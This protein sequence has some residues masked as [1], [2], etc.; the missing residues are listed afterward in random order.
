MAINQ[1]I[2][3]TLCLIAFII[4]CVVVYLKVY[5]VKWYLYIIHYWTDYHDWPDWDTVTTIWLCFKIEDEFSI[6]KTRNAIKMQTGEAPSIKDYKLIRTKRC[7]RG[8]KP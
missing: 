5:S 4:L 2:S 7:K 3:L 1:I 6:V 8:E